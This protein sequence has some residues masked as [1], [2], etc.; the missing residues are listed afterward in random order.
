M[1][2]GYLIQSAG[3]PNYIWQ[4]DYGAYELQ[5]YKLE[6]ET[7]Y[8]PVSGDRTGYAYFPSIP[9]MPEVEF[10]GDGIK[11]GFRPCP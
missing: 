5:S 4:S 7:F 6:N 8:I 10:R 9:L 1:I 11:D 3:I 2:S